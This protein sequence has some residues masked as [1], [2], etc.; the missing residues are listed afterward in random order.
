MKTR[1]KKKG[2]ETKRGAVF[3]N[4]YTRRK[5]RGERKEEENT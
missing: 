5:R 1:P 4:G 2:G 3:E